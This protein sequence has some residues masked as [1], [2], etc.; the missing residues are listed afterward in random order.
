MLTQVKPKLRKIYAKLSTN[1]YSGRFISL[2]F[3]V[4]SLLVIPTTGLFDSSW[5]NTQRRA[6]IGRGKWLP[7]LLHY[8]LIGR[9]K[10]YMPSMYFIPSQVDTYN[11]NSSRIDPII[12][13]TFISRFRDKPTHPMLDNVKTSIQKKKLKAKTIHGY[14][15][16]VDQESRR[17]Q[18]FLSKRFNFKHQNVLIRKHEGTMFRQ[19]PEHALVSIIMPVWNRESVVGEAIESIQSQTLQNWELLIADDGSTD[20]TISVLEGYAKEDKRIKVIKLDHGG[21]CAARNAAIRSAGGDWIAFLDSDNTWTPYFLSTMIGEMTENGNLAAYG[22]VE[23][24]DGRKSLYRTNEID[25]KNLSMGNFIDL[26]VLIVEKKL[27]ESVG[28]FDE[29]LR[30]MVDYDLVARLSKKS[31]IKMYPILGVNYTNHNDIERITNTERV[32]WSSVVKNKNYIDWSSKN[33]GFDG[34]SVVISFHENLPALTRCLRS[35]LDQIDQNLLNEVIIIDNS[36]TA[37]ASI[38]AASLELLSSKVFYVRSEFGSDVAL[39]FNLGFTLSKSKR[40]VLLS[41]EVDLDEGWSDLGE[42]NKLPIAVPVQL[43]SNRLIYSA[44]VVLDKKLFP[45]PIKLLENHPIEDLK[46]LTENEHVMASFDGC[47]ILNDRT[48][49]ERIKGLDPI[50]SKRVMMLD[51]SLRALKIAGTKTNLAKSIYIVNHNAKSDY[52]DE[53]YRFYFNRWRGLRVASTPTTEILQRIGFSIKEKKLFRNDIDDS[54]FV[55]LEIKRPKNAKT[56]WAIKSAHPSNASR[57]EW[58]DMYFANALRDALVRFGHDAVVDNRDTVDRPSAALDDINIVLRGL[59]RVPAMTGK[60]NVLWVISHPD[61]VSDEE[62]LEYDLVFAAGEKWAKEKTLS[63]GKEIYTLLQ[64]TNL[65]PIKESQRRKDNSFKDKIIFVGN[66]RNVYRKIVK[67]IIQTKHKV[68]V[69]GTGWEQFIPKK[70]IKA[71]HIDNTQLPVA[72]NSAEIVLNDHWDDMKKEGFISNRIFDAGASGAIVISD[73]VSGAEDI[74]PSNSFFMYDKIDELSNIIENIHRM[75]PYE[76]ERYKKEFSKKIL[77][78]HTFY[79]RAKEL[80][81]KTSRLI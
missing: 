65:K 62:I 53:D 70:F 54:L 25:M 50:Y 79:Q 58:G 13:H 28:Y 61:L 78:K 75:T 46:K 71:R 45:A 57:F 64:C 2:F 31:T 20:K 17:S 16:W 5:Y 67:D 26:N 44:G 1:R 42:D 51:F 11:W 15:E 29:E 41:T 6:Q 66:S 4:I 8:L 3:I 38:G 49:F 40:V 77:E 35:V 63:T 56:R 36:S 24:K 27:L 9:K 30:R 47:L 81:A 19:S 23:L 59:I 43:K 22:C 18:N 80:V 74:F 68:S 33:K 69:Y 73:K 10:N 52:F 21:V 60:I 34:V 7:G 72:Y 39:G 55:A 12:K 76:K 48:I 14:K 37:G 32:T